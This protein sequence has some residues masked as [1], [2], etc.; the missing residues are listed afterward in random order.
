MAGVRILVSG[1]REWADTERLAA[2]YGVDKG[3]AAQIA[4]RQREVMADTLLHAYTWAVD[5]LS[6]AGGD[7]VLVHGNAMG[8]DRLA[9]DIWRRAGEAAPERRL[10]LESHPA[11]WQKDGRSAGYQR[12]ARMV[13]AGADIGLVFHV[14]RSRGAE[15]CASLMVRAHIPVG[16]VAWRE[17]V[18]KPLVWLS[19]ENVLRFMPPLGARHT[20]IYQQLTLLDTQPEVPQCPVCG[21][22]GTHIAECVTITIKPVEARYYHDTVAGEDRCG[23]CGA[24]VS[25]APD[26]HTEELC[27]AEV[28]VEA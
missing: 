28:L 17:K 3:E 20:T 8:A 25:E 26:R 11:R 4:A 15:H 5:S 19:E 6:A 23:A 2:L 21:G 9:A 7:I 14:E 24:L 1:S 22:E 16:L 10:R 18:E 13:E 27:Y 12:N